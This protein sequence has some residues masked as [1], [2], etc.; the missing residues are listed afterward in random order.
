[1]TKLAVDSLKARNEFTRTPVA[2]GIDFV[3]FIRSVVLAKA[4]TKTNLAGRYV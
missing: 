2:I 4:V 1:M 3:D